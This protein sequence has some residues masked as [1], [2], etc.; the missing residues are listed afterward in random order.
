MSTSISSTTVD[1][2]ERK[3]NKAAHML[4]EA[5]NNLFMLTFAEADQ[6]PVLDAKVNVLRQIFSDLY[7]EWARRQI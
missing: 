1:T 4:T 5:N 2:L 6:R 3:V 7:E